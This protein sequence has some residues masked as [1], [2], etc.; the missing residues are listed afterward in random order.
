M[1]WGEMVHA[2][3][4]QSARCHGNIAERRVL[5]VR[6]HVRSSRNIGRSDARGAM[7]WDDMVGRAYPASGPVCQQLA[8]RGPVHACSCLYCGRRFRQQQ[9]PIGLAHLTASAELGHA[10]LAKAAQFQAR[11]YSLLR[12]QRKKR[13][14]AIMKEIGAGLH[15]F[16]CGLRRYDIDAVAATKLSV[17]KSYVFRIDRR[18]DEP[19]VARAFPPARPRAGVQGDAA[20]LRFR[21]WS[22][23]APV[24]HDVPGAYLLRSRG[25]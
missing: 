19:W 2:A 6:T 18:D 8:E 1:G 4:R 15:A 9:L 20:V 11:P 7:G 21:L 13:P 3:H 22:R 5:H 25:R 14:V 16:L 23:C 17:H 12:R 10:Q 24:Q